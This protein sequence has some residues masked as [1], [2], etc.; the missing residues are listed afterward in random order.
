[1]AQA[2][3]PALDTN[4]TPSKPTLQQLTTSHDQ[5]EHIISDLKVD[6]TLP[7][8]DTTE[9]I[10]TTS[11]KD[12]HQQSNTSKV[13]KKKLPSERAKL[14]D[15][16][17]TP[18]LIEQFSGRTRRGRTAQAN[19]VIQHTEV[20][21]HQKVEKQSVQ[22]ADG[23]GIQQQ[24]NMIIDHSAHANTLTAINTSTH[25]NT[26]AT[27]DI[28][29][30]QLAS[31]P[32]TPH[33]T[34]S[35]D[36]GFNDASNKNASDQ[37]QP[38]EKAVIPEAVDDFNDV[39]QP[40]P[41]LPLPQPTA[42]AKSNA[43]TKAASK[44]KAPRK[45]AESKAATP[46]K[47]KPPVKAA[48]SPVV[49]PVAVQ[50]TMPPSNAASSSSSSPYTNFELSHQASYQHFT[51]QGSPYISSPSD[52][53]RLQ[54]PN[55]PQMR[56]FVN[57][58]IQSSTNTEMYPPVDAHMQYPATTHTQLSAN[59]HMQSPAN[60]YMQPSFSAQMHPSANANYLPRNNGYARYY[61]DP[62]TS[63]YEAPR[64]LTG[65]TSSYQHAVPLH[66]ASTSVHQAPI[67]VHQTPASSFSTLDARPLPFPAVPALLVSREDT[68]LASMDIDSGTVNSADHNM[69]SMNH[70]ELPPS[71]RHG[72][73]CISF[74]YL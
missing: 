25:V 24:V 56:P 68:G 58:Q 57:A 3:H 46:R 35:T 13:A 39:F 10:P 70:T 50:H 19:Q 67:P 74:C 41:L 53:A 30:M 27:Q 45:K 22:Q 23:Q 44:P 8:N 51:A 14:E 69:P 31:S 2:N 9:S 65:S 36:V 49:S 32:A 20:Q 72:C 18:E 33:N 60:T 12:T 55:N 64:R 42:K 59:T 6:Q 15:T 5:T 1:M 40:T 21:S 17:N 61:A 63:Y 48:S 16:W 73:G 66:R 37:L 29:P 71:F 7:V 34:V 54:S 38:T 4:Q 43:K 62:P 47:R 26:T 11:N 28:L 52:N